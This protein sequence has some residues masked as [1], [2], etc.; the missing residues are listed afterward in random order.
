MTDHPFGEL[1]LNQSF[2]FTSTTYTFLSK[3]FSIVFLA[4]SYASEVIRKP[5]RIITGFLIL[6]MNL[7]KIYFQL[8]RQK[9]NVKIINKFLK[10]IYPNDNF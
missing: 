2:L 5:P 1:L 3:T 4:R 8:I 10:F 9:S 7:I 6:K